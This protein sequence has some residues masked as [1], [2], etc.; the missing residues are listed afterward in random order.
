MVCKFVDID[1]HRGHLNGIVGHISSQLRSTA[2]LSRGLTECEIRRNIADAIHGALSI[3]AFRIVRGIG[4]GYSALHDK[5]HDD[6]HFPP[7]SLSTGFPRLSRR[8]GDCGLRPIRDCGEGGMP[9]LW[10]LHH[11][12][13]AQDMT[14]LERTPGG[15]QE[16]GFDKCCLAPSV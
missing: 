6:E 15:A 1:A 13:P 12:P 8:R 10:L 7:P 14:E 11:A 2:I 9:P 4:I 3:L 16:I 5:L